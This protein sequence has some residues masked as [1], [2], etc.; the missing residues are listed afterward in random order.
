LLRVEVE[1]SARPLLLFRQSA[2]R[3]LLGAATDDEIAAVSASELVFAPGNAKMAAMLAVA[4]ALPLAMASAP[5]AA[6]N[7]RTGGLWRRSTLF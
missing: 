5:S 2:W 4:A 3:L 7:L 6:I 1:E